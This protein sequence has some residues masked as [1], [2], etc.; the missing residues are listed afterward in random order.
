[1]LRLRLPMQLHFL[2]VLRPRH[3]PG[4]LPVYVQH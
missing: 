1:L 4:L 3:K 2:T